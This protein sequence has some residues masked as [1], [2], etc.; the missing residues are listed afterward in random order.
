MAASS[1]APFTAAAAAAARRRR[2]TVAARLIH[3]APRV[4][5]TLDWDTLD[6]AP[7]WLSLPDEQLIALQCRIG[8][9]LHSRAMHLWIDGARLGA[10]RA[11]LGEPFLR[12]LLA[13]PEVAALPTGSMNLPR[14]DTAMQVSP[15][16]RAAGASVLLA[17]L[18]PGPLHSAA[19]T[20]LAPAAAAE[21]HAEL[22]QT[23]IARAEP[24]M[25]AA[26]APAGAAA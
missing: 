15:L 22:A 17:S 16:L 7:L 21:M 12:G 14:I 18:Q 11:V 20:L 8:A 13:Q 9:L 6:N 1:S 25:Q 10:A 23:L 4:A 24:P 2:T 19:A 3:Q 26:T 5:A